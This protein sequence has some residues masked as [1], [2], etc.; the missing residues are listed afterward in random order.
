[1][2]KAALLLALCCSVAS[3]VCADFSATPFATTNQSP[4]IQLYG[5]PRD[6]SAGITP[7]GTTFLRLSHDLTSNYTSSTNSR[8]QVTLDSENYRTTISARY[9]IS[10]RWEIGIDIPYISYNGGFLDGF[11]VNW[12]DTFGLPQGGRNIT[13]RDRTRISYRVNRNQLLDRDSAASGPGD[14]ALNAG[15]QVYRSSST[16]VAL[17]GGIKLPSGSSSSLLGSGST[18]MQLQLCASTTKGTFGT[19][20]AVGVL[21]MADS[22][23]LAEQHNPVAGLA[24]AGLGW[25]AAPWLAFKAQLNGV[26]SLYRNS[27]LAE[28]GSPSLLLITGGTIDLSHGYLLDMGVA[29]D[30]AVATAPDVS[31]HLS[32][33]SSF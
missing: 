30:V 18:D 10:P 4:L 32:L 12:H 13:V 29:E 2:N 19:F 14:I 20:G 26:T 6:S 23:I 22:H 5:L 33:S 7:H 27:T 11:I 24:M 28:V 25:Q 9:G 17:K 1:M 16:Q 3:P 15:Y 8:E 31:F 21:A